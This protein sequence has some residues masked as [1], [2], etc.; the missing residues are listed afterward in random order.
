MTE[1]MDEFVEAMHEVFPKLLIQ[2]EDFSTENAFLYLER[3]RY[4]YPVFNDDIQ[5]SESPTLDYLTME[6]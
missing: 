3:F 1:F 6:C 2:F 4:S 5:G